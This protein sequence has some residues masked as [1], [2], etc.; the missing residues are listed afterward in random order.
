MSRAADPLGAGY[1]VQV[2]RKT[3]A[4]LRSTSDFNCAVQEL[5]ALVLLA[6]FGLGFVY[7]GVSLAWGDEIAAWWKK[8]VRKY[9][10]KNERS[11]YC[12]PPG[13]QIL[14]SFSRMVCVQC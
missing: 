9:F 13:E 11:E 5:I 3:S 12:P 1:T 14:F 2:V 10:K 7:L 8:T 4:G 6:L